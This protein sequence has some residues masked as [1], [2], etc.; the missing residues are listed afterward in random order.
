MTAS[1]DAVRRPGHVRRAD[2]STASTPSL[3]EEPGRGPAR[4]A[5]AR[6]RR[7]GGRAGHGERA[8]PSSR[9]GIADDLLTVD[10]ARVRPARSS[11][12]PAMHT[13]MWE[14]PATQANVAALAARGVRVRRTGRR[15][16]RRTAT[17]ASGRMTEPEEHRC[18]RSR[19]RCPRRGTS[20]ARAIVVTAGPT[21][22][23]IDP[24]RFIGNR[25][26]GKM[27]VAVA[28]RGARPGRRVTL[29]ARAR[30]PSSRPRG[31]ERGP[32]DDRRR[33]ARGRARRG[34]GGGRGRDGGGRRRLPSQGRGATGK[35]KKETGPAGARSRAHPR[36]PGRAGRARRDP[37]SPG[38]VRGRDRGRRGRRPREARGARA[39]D[40]ARRERGG[41]GGHRVRRATPTTRRS[42]P[43]TATTS[44]LRDVDQARARRGD[45]RPPRRAARPR[46]AGRSTVGRYTPRDHEPGL[47]VLVRIRHRGTP[48]Q[49]RRPDLRR[50]P[51]RDPRGGPGQ[52]RRVRDAGDDRARHRRRRDHDRRSTSTSPRSCAGHDR[53]DRLHGRELRDRR[54]HLRRDHVDPGAVA[55]HRA[56][57]RRRARAS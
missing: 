4:P 32:R 53:R 24:V 55:R 16:A 27:G 51:G 29:V 20:R 43:P 15:A 9:T 21:H 28:A 49:A 50:G 18:G 33:D 38:R 17:R 54:R 22:E 47:S 23:P 45:L 46:T 25:S 52:P 31:A 1:A 26:S 2:R 35:L 41:P 57:G 36:H 30:R 48:R 5:R 12:A 44:P 8:S 6:G 42:W 40:L 13:G 19:T 3:W 34:R 10:A 37:A 39:C 56:R 7:R 14:H 11:L